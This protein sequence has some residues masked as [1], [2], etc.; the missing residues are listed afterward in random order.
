MATAFGCTVLTT[1]RCGAPWWTIL[2]YGLAKIITTKRG[3]L[4]GAHIVG[5]GAADVIHELQIVKALNKPLHRIYSVTHAYPTYAQ[6]LVGRAGQLAYL[7]RM[8]TN[9]FVNVGLTLL[10]GFENKLSMA[11]QRLAES[12]EAA[13]LMPPVLKH[14]DVSVK[15]VGET[16]SEIRFNAVKI[17]DKA[18]L[19]DMP[20]DLNG[21][22]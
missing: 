2:D 6:A 19:V 7:D 13:P 11:R 22:R 8:C 17:D 15:G 12:E 10:P 9:P 5:E 18:C 14:I 16:A 3:K 4:L 20:A 21:L 1:S